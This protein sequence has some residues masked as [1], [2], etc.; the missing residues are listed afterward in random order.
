MMRRLALALG[1]LLA[2]SAGASAQQC[3]IGPSSLGQLIPIQASNTGT[4]GAVV[5]TLAAAPAKTTFIC[6]FTVTSGGGASAALL[7]V[8][9]SGIATTMTFQYL[10]PASGQGVLGAAFPV[11]IPASGQNTAIVVTKSA[12]GTATA[13]AVNAW[14]CQQ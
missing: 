8:T 12:T 2:L 5:A 10:D 6:G 1:V 14:G 7:A 13:S 4:T 3:T 9:I 11:C